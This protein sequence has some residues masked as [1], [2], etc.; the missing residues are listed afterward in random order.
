M[1]LYHGSN[2]FI[3]SIDL[4]KGK[5][6]KDFGQGFYATHIREQ[7]VYWSNRIQDRF[8]GTATERSLKYISR[9]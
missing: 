4:S 1:K 6:H 8:G 9:L 2:Q 5:K 3:Q 7:A